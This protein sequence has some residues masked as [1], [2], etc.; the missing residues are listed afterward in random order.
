MR[1][2]RSE[3]VDRVDTD[4]CTPAFAGEP[5]F[6]TGVVDPW[7]RPEQ[8]VLHGL[9]FAK[10]SSPRRA[11]RRCRWSGWVPRG[12]YGVWARARL[13]HSRRPLN[14][15][16]VHGRAVWPFWRRSACEGRDAPPVPGFATDGCGAKGGHWVKGEE[17]LR[18]RGLLSKWRWALRG[19]CVMAS[20][21]WP[22]PT[23]RSL[24]A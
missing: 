8:R 10:S 13:T 2:N 17:S 3:Y 4:G 18:R 15:L 19:G 21:C 20:P 11:R 5:G 9:S 6:K 23:S 22:G 7:T 14:C 16:W 24:V 1:W 12:L